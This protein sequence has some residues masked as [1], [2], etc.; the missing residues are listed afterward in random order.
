MRIAVPAAAL[1]FVLSGAGAWASDDAWRALPHVQM[2]EEDSHPHEV[3][4]GGM[5]RL[6]TDPVTA[7][8]L[9]RVKCSLTGPARRASISAQGMELKSWTLKSATFD[10]APGA[11]LW[12]DIDA[13]V[14]PDGGK[15]AYFAFHNLDAGALLWHQC[16]NN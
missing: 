9:M 5:A 7:P 4:P 6:H 12:L 13:V 2:Q 1:I 3:Q 14:Y 15:A 16:Y 11:T 8:R 10:I